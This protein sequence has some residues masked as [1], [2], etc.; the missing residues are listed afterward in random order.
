MQ[1]VEIVGNGLGEATER[2]HTLLLAFDT[3]F[4]FT[5]GDVANGEDCSDRLISVIADDDI[6]FYRNF[7]ALLLKGEQGVFWKG[8]AI[9]PFGF[10]ES[11]GRQILFFTAREGQELVEVLAQ[12]FRLLGAEKLFGG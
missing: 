12:Q 2:Q 9:A 5:A 3:F 10:V 1:A 7:T 4:L 8:D 11:L 6:A